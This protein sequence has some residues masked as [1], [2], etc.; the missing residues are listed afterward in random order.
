MQYRLL[1]R[2]GLRVSELCLGTMTFGAEW[3]FGAD[4]AGSRAQLEAFAEAG[5]NFVDTANRY[6]EGTSERYVGELIQ[7]DRNYWVVAT[8]YTLFNR[9]GDPNAAGNHRKNLVQSLEASLKRLGTDYVD[10]LYLHA[11]DG[12][13]PVEEVMR[14]LEDVVS[15]GKALYIAISDTPAWVIAQANM[16]ADLRGWRRF[17][18]LQ[19][20][21]SLIQRTVERELLPMAKATDLGVTAWGAFGGGALTGKYLRDPNAAGRVTEKSERRSER[22]ERITRKVVEIADELQVSAT[23]VALNWV[24]Q[25]AQVVI[26]VIGARTAD[27]LRDSLGCLNF[28]LSEAHMQALNDVSAIE[29]G[30]PHDFLH[31]PS[32]NNLVYAG[33]RDRI[34]N[35]RA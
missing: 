34:E 8:K 2:S 20:E 17:I 18:G 10:V 11:W 9:L 29:M 24:R 27:Q 13:T 22:A 4:Q 19:V 14:G 5:G 33:L 26:P 3:G 15:A 12:L 21:Y 7:A 25:Q 30:F 16:L 31:Q 6:T 1:G 35:H 32:I 23:Q 28:R